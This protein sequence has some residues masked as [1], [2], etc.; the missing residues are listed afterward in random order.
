MA[1]VASYMWHHV[2]LSVYIYFQI[3]TDLYDRHSNEFKKGIRLP[4]TSS[5]NKLE[6]IYLWQSKITKYFW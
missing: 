6:E 1:E 5:V 2:G 4:L 3:W